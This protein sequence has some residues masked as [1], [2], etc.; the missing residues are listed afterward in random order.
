MRV[1]PG[2]IK[3]VFRIA[4]R[5]AGRW[6]TLR[7]AVRQRLG[8]DAL[9]LELN[10]GLD[11][12]HR[13]PSGDVPLHMAM[14]QPYAR[15]VGLE[16]HDR[17]AGWRNHHGVSLHWSR[18]EARI[19]TVILSHCMATHVFRAGYVDPGTAS[20]ELHDVAMHV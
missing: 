1:R 2:E 9:L 10:R 6:H 17:V 20:D 3:V 11:E 13:Q 14:Q 8:R 7:L 5:V 15:V 16:S 4:R 12:G 18:G 19:N